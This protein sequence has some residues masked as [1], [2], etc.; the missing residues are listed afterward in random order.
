MKNSGILFACLASS[1]GFIVACGG[2]PSAEQQAAADQAR[3]DSLKAAEMEAEQP[4]PLLKEWPLGFCA[5]D[6]H[7]FNKTHFNLCANIELIK[8][9]S[10]IMVVRVVDMIGNDAAGPFILTGEKQGLE[11][12]VQASKKTF[13]VSAC[14]K[15][16]IGE[17][18]VSLDVDIVG[19]GPDMKIS[20]KCTLFGNKDGSL[21]LIG[22]N[23][24]RDNG[25]AKVDAIAGD[26][27]N[28]PS[29]HFVHYESK[30][31]K[32]GVLTFTAG[33]GGKLIDGKFCSIEELGVYCWGC[34]FQYKAKAC[35]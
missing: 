20:E 11:V 8:D 19:V 10:S 18:D 16:N 24:T 15:C 31:G 5:T 6:D 21:A 2:G 7:E 33:I 27:Q 35:K 34:E 13:T 14:S 26:C 29:A 4:E 12:Q 9:D 32:Q 22:G 23:D 17:G 25:I 1:F 28:D 3:L 30:S